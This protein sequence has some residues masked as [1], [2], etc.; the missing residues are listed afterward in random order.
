MKGV[1]DEVFA[2]VLDYLVETG[3]MKL[4]DLIYSTFQ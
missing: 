4:E 2:S 3:H 1:I